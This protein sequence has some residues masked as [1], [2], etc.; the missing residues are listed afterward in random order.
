[1]EPESAEYKTL[2]KCIDKLRIAFKFS[3]VSI[4]DEL[5]ANGFVSSEAHS[6]ILT[7]SGWGEDEKAS[8]LV[9]CVTDIVSVCSGKYH[10]FMAL[11]MF[12]NHGL[13]PLYDVITTEYGKELI[14]LMVAI[15]EGSEGCRLCTRGSMVQRWQSSQQR[16]AISVPGD[17]CKQC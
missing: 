15:S 17:N 3:L 5:L 10:D 14:Q 1:M 11:P 8:R 12:K 2:I 13:S 16:G 9:K 7:T 6:N 4:A